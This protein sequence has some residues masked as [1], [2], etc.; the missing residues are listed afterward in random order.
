M[1]IQLFLLTVLFATGAMA[2]EKTDTVA[3]CIASFAAGNMEAYSDSVTAIRLWGDISDPN[4]KEAASACLALSSDTPPPIAVTAKL[5]GEDSEVTAVLQPNLVDSYLSRLEATP[6]SIEKVATEIAQNETFAPLRDDKTNRLENALLAYA[7]P[8]PASKADANR[9]AYLALSRLD[10]NNANYTQKILQ[11]TAAIEAR[12]R[13]D[14]E[15]K[16]TIVSRLIKQ[17]AEFDGSSWYRHASSPR[18]QD[19]KSYVTLYVLE[20]GGGQRSLEFFLN[21]T[22]RNGWLFVESAQINVDGDIVRLPPSQWSRDND[23]EIWEWTGFSNQPAMVELARRIAESDRSV[24]RFNGQQ[25]YDD[26]VIS[27]TEKTVIRDMLLAWDEMKG[28]V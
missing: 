8:L 11:Y 21:Y 5:V 15:R 18:Y 4:L 7:K 26:H 17:T 3:G 20:T 19:Q 14:E 25:F 24:V 1:R 10:P 13:V 9:V 23:S 6:S 12:T 27:K 16:A 2:D 22:S 28:N